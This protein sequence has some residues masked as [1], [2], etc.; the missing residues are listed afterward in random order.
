MNHFK[1][2]LRRILNVFRCRWSRFWSIADRPLASVCSH[3]RLTTL[4]YY[5][6][7]NFQFHREQQAVLVGRRNYLSDLRRPQES[8]ALLRR[9][10]HRLEKGLLMRPRRD[11]FALGYLEET[12]SCYGEMINVLEGQSCSS[13]TSVIALTEMKWAHDVL[14]EF[15]QVTASPRRHHH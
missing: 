2:K 13:E 10:T 12:V 11:V 8:S 7:F 5:T 9:N 4:F 14:D 1:N 3:S 15:F 6:F